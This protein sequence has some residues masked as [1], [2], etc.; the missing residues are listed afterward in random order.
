METNQSRAIIYDRKNSRCMKSWGSY[1]YVDIALNSTYSFAGNQ[2][3][4]HSTG[5]EKYRHC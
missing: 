1:K 2:N 4:W 5:G 3:R